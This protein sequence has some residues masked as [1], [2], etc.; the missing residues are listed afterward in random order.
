MKRSTY[1]VVV[2]A[3]ETGHR[4]WAHR[5][6]GDLPPLNAVDQSTGKLINSLL[7]F[8]LVEI[9]IDVSYP[10]PPTPSAASPSPPLDRNVFDRL[11]TSRRESGVDPLLYDRQ[12]SHFGSNLP[13]QF[14]GISDHVSLRRQLMEEAPTILWPTGQL[15]TTVVPNVRS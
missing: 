8:E 9:S 12:K 6:N 10:L 4:V 15:K 1:I 5:R 3:S 11:I 7:R 14:G 2:S 13:S